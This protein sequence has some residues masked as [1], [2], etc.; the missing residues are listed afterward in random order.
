MSFGAKVSDRRF[1]V[2]NR[3]SPFHFEFVLFQEGEL[4]FFT[5]HPHEI[6]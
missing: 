1:S 2:S 6:M 3:N 5:I 4:S